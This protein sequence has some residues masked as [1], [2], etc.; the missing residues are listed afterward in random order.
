MMSDLSFV[1]VSDDEM[2][3][4]DNNIDTCVVGIYHHVRHWKRQD[5]LR[6]RI[7]PFN[8]QHYKWFPSITQARYI[9]SVLSSDILFLPT[10]ELSS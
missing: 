1:V 6:C 10:Q 7:F 8:L 5:H 3:N 9:A 2:Q 4:V